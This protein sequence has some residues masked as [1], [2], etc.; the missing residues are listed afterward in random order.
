LVVRNIEDDVKAKLQRRARMH[1]RSTE[2]EVRD[3]LRNAVRDQ[4]EPQ[5][6]LGTR[7]VALF[8]GIGLREEI[9]ELRGHPARPAD[10]DS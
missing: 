10:F 9:P 3:I 7:I 5:Q 1:G 2:E 4:G 8:E 6:G